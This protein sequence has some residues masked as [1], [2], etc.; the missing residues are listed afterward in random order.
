MNDSEVIA[1]S[2]LVGLGKEL[3]AIRFEPHGKRTPDFLVDN[4]IAVEVRRLNQ[5]YSH[6]GTSRGL[7]EASIPLQMRLRRLLLSFGPPN[8]RQSWFVNYKFRRPLPETVRLIDDLRNTLRSF[9]DNPGTA[10]STQ[11]KLDRN[12]EVDLLRTSEIHSMLFLLG[13]SID[14]DSGGWVRPEL[15]RNLRMAVQEK[16]KVVSRYLG[17]Y[18]E[19]WLILVDRIS[20]GTW[21]R[22][23]DFSRAL[24]DI[25][26]AF[27]KIILVDQSDPPRGLEL[28]W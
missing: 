25:D 21:D 24:S 9:K 27:S 11:I 8:R 15:E 26:H 19:W 12:F 2:Y 20:H 22:A 7:E 14:R 4:R 13:A 17:D 28:S 18:P 6:E 3:K 16:A 1:Y 23:K 5:H 10:P